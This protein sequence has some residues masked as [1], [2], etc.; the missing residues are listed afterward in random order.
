MLT[1]EDFGRINERNNRRFRASIYVD[2]FIPD[3]GDLEKDRIRA[4]GLVKRAADS[5]SGKLGGKLG[6]AYVGGVASYN[7]HNLNPLDKE[8]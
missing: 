8:I 1:F 5:I 2:V 4:E 6:N 7:P 3:S